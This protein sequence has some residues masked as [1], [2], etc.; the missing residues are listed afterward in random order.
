MVEANNLIYMVDSSGLLS[1]VTKDGDILWNVPTNTEISS[2]LS[3]VNNML[4]VG[5]SSA[6]LL[7]YDINNLSLNKHTAIISSIN[8][9]ITFEQY[10]SDI[11][12]DLITEL[13]SPI[14]NRNNLLVLKL[15]NDDIFMVDSISRDTVWE[16]RGQNIPLKTK[17]SSMPVLTD[18]KIIVARDNG[19]VSSYNAI[20]GTLDWFTIISSRSG[21]NELESQ[22]D[23]EMEI[24]IDSDRVIYGHYQGSITSIDIKNGETIWSSPFSFS[25]DLVI[26]NNSIY[27]STSD[28]H[29]ISL[30]RASGFVN[31][32]HK[33]KDEHKLTQPVI[34][35]DILVVFSTNG[36]IMLF[37]KTLGQIISLDDIGYE[38]HHQ[39]NIIVD[40][41]NIYLQTLNGKLINAKLIDYNY[42]KYCSFKMLK[43]LL[44]TNLFNIKIQLFLINMVLLEIMK[45]KFFTKTAM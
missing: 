20:D 33:I 26:N 40:K 14:I 32:K 12:I 39:T 34:I 31:W 30:D 9:A 35:D 11:E 4:C 16:S 29:L 7:C 42:V 13:S 19:S 36:Y 15:D 22:R 3:V 28:N 1:A 44:L 18:D 8:N 21:R 23:A 25:N 5:S 45:V 37:D 6:K 10:P 43:S 41:N 38:L 2:G 27:G 24:L 17:G